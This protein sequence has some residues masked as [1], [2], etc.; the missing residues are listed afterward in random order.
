MIPIKLKGILG[1]GGLIVQ[2]YSPE[3][4]TATGLLAM[5]AGAFLAVK[6][7]LKFETTLKLA[8]DRVADLKADIDLADTPE[9]E[10]VNQYASPEEMKHALYKVYLINALEFTKLYGPAVSLFLSGAG[11]IV[12]GHGIMRKRNV[13]LIAAYN[14]VEKSFAAYRARVLED[15]GPDKDRDYRL[16]I[17]ETT[18]QGQDGKKRN[19]TDVDP[20]KMSKYSRIFDQTNDNWQKEPGYNQFFL[21]SEQNWM[22]DLLLYRGHVFL[23]EVY[24]RL[25]FDRTPEGAVVGWLV[26]KEG[27]NFIDFG[28]YDASEQVKRNFINGYEKSIWLDFNVDGVIFDKL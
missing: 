14:A 5:G 15:L 12:V 6:A 4:L 8:E 1:R 16:G 23:N 10:H 20:S 22:N 27:D 18:E 2:K 24:D 7:T 17:T 26:S 13:S 28:V 9:V 21:N 19:V 11:A 3:I 25:G